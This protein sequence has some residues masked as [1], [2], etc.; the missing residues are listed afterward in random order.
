[1]RYVLEDEFHAEWLRE[2]DTP[3]AAITELRRLEA[4]TS[5]QLVREI[6]PTPCGRQ[7]VRDLHVIEETGKEIAPAKAR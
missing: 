7:C 3:E 4:L 5:A 1:M 2:F 6:G